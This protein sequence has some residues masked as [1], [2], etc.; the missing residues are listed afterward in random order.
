MS[1]PSPAEGVLTF[2]A[3]G[4]EG[5][6]FHSRILRVPTIRSGL[7]IG[8]GYDCKTRMAAKIESDLTSAGLDQAAAKLLSRAAGLAGVFAEKFIDTHN[9]RTFEI[10]PE[11]QLKLF[12]AMY[13]EELLETKCLCTKADVQS[14]YG[15]CD[16]KELHPA[17]KEVL[18][19][20]KFRGDYT[21]KARQL[22]QRHVASNDL[23]S[24]YEILSDKNNW[25]TVPADRFNRRVAH[26]KRHM[27]ALTT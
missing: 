21:P 13:R 12:K 8:R 7:T 26:L 11:Q 5:G 6:P 22:I 14:V 1:V 15:S 2:E 4:Q 24:F 20:L 17:I 25:L 9:L 18:V 27:A 19:D 10:T 3:E 16:W 23:E